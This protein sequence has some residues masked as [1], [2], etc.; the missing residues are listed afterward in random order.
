MDTVVSSVKAVV[1]LHRAHM[2]KYALV[3]NPVINMLAVS[4][5]SFTSALVGVE[6]SMTKTRDGVL[7]ASVIIKILE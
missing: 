5:D 2:E 1:P 4:M 6:N 3:T 7:G